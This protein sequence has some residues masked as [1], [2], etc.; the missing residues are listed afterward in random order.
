VDGDGGSGTPLLQALHAG[1]FL[2]FPIL[3]GEQP[4][5]A[6]LA[7]SRTPLEPFSEED[8]QLFTLISRQV[9][10]TLQNLRLLTET[11]QRLAEVNLLLDFNRH[12]GGLDPSGISQTLAQSVLNLIPAS[13]AVMVAL[14]DERSRWLVPQAI[15]GMVTAGPLSE[16]AYHSG[17]ALP[18]QVYAS[19]QPVILDE[20]FCPPF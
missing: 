17:E 2:C 10:I 16:I 14:W 13:Q 4:D 8:E 19:G 5:A 7:I 12:L 15:T 20:G 3:S 1:A 6:I 9:G 11:S 18:G